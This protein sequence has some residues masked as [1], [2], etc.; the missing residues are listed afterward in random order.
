MTLWQGDI[1]SLKV[2]ESYQLK[3]LSVRSYMNQKYLSPVK[4]GFDFVAIEDIGTVMDKPAEDENPYELKNVE[5]AAISHFNRGRVCIVCKG[6][7]EPTNNRLGICCKCSATQ[8]L[9]KCP[10]EISVKLLVG[11]Q[12]STRTLYAYLPMIQVIVIYR[13]RGAKHE[14]HNY[15]VSHPTPMALTES[16]EYVS[17]LYTLQPQQSSMGLKL[18]MNTINNLILVIFMINLKPIEVLL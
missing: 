2:D 16:M 13:V 11:P 15:F 9:D 14:V 12:G 3:N 7:V 6:K 4:S 18:I 8:R 17:P 1:G 5:V 10:L